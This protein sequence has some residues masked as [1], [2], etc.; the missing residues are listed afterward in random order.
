MTSMFVLI[1]LLASS[2]DAIGKPKRIACTTDTSHYVY[3]QFV[4]LG[5]YLACLPM[6]RNHV[7]PAYQGGIKTHLVS[8]MV[9]NPVVKGLFYL[10][11][12]A[13]K[14]C[15]KGKYS[16]PGD[17]RCRVCLEGQMSDNE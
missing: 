5:E 4:Q 13:C 11:Q 10:G 9:D 3:L 1:A 2:S 17:F 15:S 12:V 14:I 7:S 6:E 16:Q 8:C